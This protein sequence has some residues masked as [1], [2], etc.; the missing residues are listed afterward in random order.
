VLDKSVRR[1]PHHQGRRHVAKESSLRKSSRHGRPDG[2]RSGL[3]AADAAGDGT[4]TATGTGRAI[5]REGLQS[6]QQSCQ[7]STL[8]SHARERRLLPRPGE[9]RPGPGVAVAP[10]W[11]LAQLDVSALAYKISQRRTIGSTIKTANLVRSPLQEILNRAI[12]LF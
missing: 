12:L 11:V 4:T 5:V 6:G 3:K 1:T 2:A 8:A 9:R 10:S 7:P